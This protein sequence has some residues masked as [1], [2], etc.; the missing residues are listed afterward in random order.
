MSEIMARIKSLRVIPVVTVE[1]AEDMVPLADTLVEGGLPCAEITL[2]TPAAADALKMVADRSDILIGAGTVLTIDQ[3]K[4]A[5]DAGARFVVSPGFNPTVAGYCINNN[6]VHAPGICTPTEIEAALDL[7]IR[8]LKFFPAEACG[9]PKN[10]KAICGPYPS[11]DF[12]PT[13]GI[14][15]DN[16]ADYLRL[17]SVLACGGSWM[18]DST[19]IGEGRFADILNNVRKTVRVIA[20]CA[21]MA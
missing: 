7:G 5:M 15:L 3:V 20:A 6:I 11:V 21:K 10:L 18:A 14:K 12:I 8:V 2:R 4:T 13:G 19:S 16:L 9:G 1:R 17:S